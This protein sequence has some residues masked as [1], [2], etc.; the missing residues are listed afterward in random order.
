ML[1]SIA[2]D[3]PPVSRPTTQIPRRCP[4]S[5]SGADPNNWKL[6]ESNIYLVGAGVAS[7]GVEPVITAVTANLDHL[8]AIRAELFVPRGHRVYR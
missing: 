8:N 1:L 6:S 3:T 7:V 5:S 2:L 4:A